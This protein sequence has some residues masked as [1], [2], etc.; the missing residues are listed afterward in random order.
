MQSRRSR[1][2]KRRGFS[3]RRTKRPLGTTRAQRYSKKQ[4]FGS[5][6]ESVEYDG[7]SVKEN[8]FCL[9]PKKYSI[10][11]FDDVLLLFAFFR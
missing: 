11:P 2:R 6:V 9:N 5:Q 4:D 8:I 1:R 3:K 7:K 10:F